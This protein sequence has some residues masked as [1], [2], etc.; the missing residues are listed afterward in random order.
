MRLKSIEIFNLAGEK[1]RHLDG[2]AVF[3][4]GSMIQRNRYATA[5]N[6]WDFTT[7]SGHTISS[8]TY[9]IKFN[10]DLFNSQDGN[11][12]GV[13]MIKKVLILR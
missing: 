4:S 6:W 2:E 11:V 10:A 7:D 8:G 5:E 13:S 1:I 3:A 12:E 9:W